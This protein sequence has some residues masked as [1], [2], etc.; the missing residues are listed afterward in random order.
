M[1]RRCGALMVVLLVGG[2]VGGCFGPVVRPAVD[3][4]WCPDGAQ[5]L[6]DYRFWSLSTTVP[7]HYVKTLSWD[8]GDGSPAMTGY[9]DA[10][11][12]FQTPDTYLVTLVATD[13][14]GVSGTT[15]KEVAIRAA[16]F[17]R[18]WRLTLGFPVEVTGEVENRSTY[19]LPTVTIKAKFY[20]A[21]GLRLTE[22]TTQISDL[23]PGE[24]AFF[25]VTA[26]A[27]TSR[28]FSAQVSVDAFTV[29]CPAD[30][31]PRDAASR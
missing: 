13:D 23:E 7:G 16:A 25:T 27:F 18:T 30:P 24:R 10:I 14:R 29:D 26:Q 20:D 4:A 3:F 6:L 1:I 17:I 22:G 21:D 9:G 15:S 19:S 11:H 28:I 2:L 8:F 5:G 12:R 31:G